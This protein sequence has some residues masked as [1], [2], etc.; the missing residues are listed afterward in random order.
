M[1]ARVSACST[2]LSR[3][4][5][6]LTPAA[7]NRPAPE[8]NTAAPKGP[9]VAR[10]TFWRASSIATRM[11]S[12]SER[13]TACQSTAAS[14]Q[15]GASMTSEVGGV[16]S[17]RVIVNHPPARGLALP[18]GGEPPA[19]L[20]LAPAV[21]DEAAHHERVVLAQRPNGHLLES[22]LLDRFSILEET[23]AQRVGRLRLA[24]DG[25]LPGHE[26]DGIG[27]VGQVAVQVSPIP[28]RGRPIQ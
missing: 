6:L 12:S 3:R 21:E 9:P 1:I 27:V 14:S 26:G 13:Y 22:Q 10:S 25:T 24:H 18:D 11:R 2:E 16:M 19:V 8:A 4:V 5:T 28:G 23:A 7:I 17:A 20:R 15:S